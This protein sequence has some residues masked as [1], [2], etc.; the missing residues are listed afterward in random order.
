MRTPSD[1]AQLTL[2]TTEMPREIPLTLTPRQLQR[3]GILK[4]NKSITDAVVGGI[5]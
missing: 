4:V 3:Y 5:N 2:L 1:S